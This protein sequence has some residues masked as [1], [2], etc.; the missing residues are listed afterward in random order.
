MAKVIEKVSK[1]C[2]EAIFDFDITEEG[3][4][5]GL[6][7]LAH[8][9]YF[10]INNGPYYH[11]F[12]VSQE[13]QS[14]T[15]NGNPNIF[16]NPGAARGWFTRSV[17]DYDKW[18]PSVLFLTHYFPSEPV[19]SQ[20]QNLASLML[21]Q[22][23]IWGEIN[24]LSQESVALISKQLN[25]YKQVR[26]D[27]TSSTLVQSGKPGDSCEVY[28]KINPANGRGLVVLFA[29]TQGKYVYQTKSKVEPR[30]IYP[31]GT[32]CKISEG[33]RA[34]INVCIGKKETVIIY[35]GIDEG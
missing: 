4:C 26:D 20:M 16:V 18:I 15:A 34:F 12:D 1:Q 17:L 11:N 9:K 13:W 23:G 33:G 32:D 22:N 14:P 29:N 7:F 8:G 2:P 25:Y 3:R 35:F 19:S 28:E 27:V 5:V 10:A 24:S 30:I 31:Q 21:G 6:Q